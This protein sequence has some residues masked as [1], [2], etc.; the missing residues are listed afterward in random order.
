MSH[1][2]YQYADYRANVTGNENEN[3]YGKPTATQF[4]VLRGTILKHPF[5]IISYQPFK[6]FKA[7]KLL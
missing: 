3:K 2:S 7:S 1:L 4:M 6:E 5:H